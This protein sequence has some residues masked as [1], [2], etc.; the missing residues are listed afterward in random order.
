M[1]SVSGYI[2]INDFDVDTS[3]SGQ[4]TAKIIE[5]LKESVENGAFQER[6]A[7]SVFYFSFFLSQGNLI[8]QKPPNNP[9]IRHASFL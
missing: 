4:Q 5:R 1:A 6:A 3:A 7:N 9:V 8:L 2:N